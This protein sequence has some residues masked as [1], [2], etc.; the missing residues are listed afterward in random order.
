MHHGALPHGRANAPGIS[1]TLLLHYRCLVSYWDS[2]ENESS[3]TTPNAGQGLS[4]QL[5]LATVMTI[6]R[7]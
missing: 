3:Q 6:A 4:L 5:C 2:I 1:N 7:L